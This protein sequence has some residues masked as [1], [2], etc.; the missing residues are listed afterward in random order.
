MFSK[1]VKNLVL[2]LLKLW[3]FFSSKFL[4]ISFNNFTICRSFVLLFIFSLKLISPISNI[5]LFY[6]IIILWVFVIKYSANFSC[7][8]IFVIQFQRFFLNLFRKFNILFFI[9]L[10]FII[11]SIQIFL[12][13]VYRG[14]LCDL[15][16]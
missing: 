9:G 3:F 16:I 7:L 8:F 14:V 1:F 13:C 11:W 10:F 2:H 15:K 5:A 4:S 12:H 6:L